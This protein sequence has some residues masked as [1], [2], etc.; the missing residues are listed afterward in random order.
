MRPRGSG[1]AEDVADREQRL[2]V[3]R[4]IAERLCHGSFGGAKFVVVL[5]SERTRHDSEPYPRPWR[6]DLRTLARC[7]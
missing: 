4:Q 5:A 6:A 7:R 2:E 3:E 1:R